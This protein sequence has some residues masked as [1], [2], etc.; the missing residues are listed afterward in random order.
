MTFHER[1]SRQLAF[2]LLLG[3]LHTATAGLPA[4]GCPDAMP[5]DPNPYLQRLDALLEGAPS[6]PAC[7]HAMLVR[8]FR[9]YSSC[10]SWVLSGAALGV[11]GY[12]AWQ[13]ELQRHGKVPPWAEKEAVKAGSIHAQHR[14]QLPGHIVG[15]GIDMGYDGASEAEIHRTLFCDCL[16]AT[17]DKGFDTTTGTFTEPPSC[18]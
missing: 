17:G 5:K 18:P 16:I 3:T 4:P 1:P 8:R 2:G 15:S 12:Q 7:E 9:N 11:Q 14:D 10:Q 6:L 13:G